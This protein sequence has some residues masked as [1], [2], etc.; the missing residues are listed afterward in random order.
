MQNLFFVCSKPQP[1]EKKNTHTP[2]CFFFFWVAINF[3]ITT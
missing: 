2:L 3:K 1:M